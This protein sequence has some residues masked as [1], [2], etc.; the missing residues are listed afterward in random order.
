MERRS[1]MSVCHPSRYDPDGGRN[2]HRRTPSSWVWVVVRA[3]GT[4]NQPAAAPSTFFCA[5]S[6]VVRAAARRPRRAHN[7]LSYH[8]HRHVQEIAARFRCCRRRRRRHRH[9]KRCLCPV[10]CGCFRLLD[11]QAGSDHQWRAWAR[12]DYN[13]HEAV[14]GPREAGPEEAR[15]DRGAQDRVGPPGA[16][17]A[18]GTSSANRQHLAQRS[19]VS[20][21][22]GRVVSS[23]FPLVLLYASA[24]LLPV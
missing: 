2:V 9:K 13:A 22:R 1:I 21:G 5:A 24:S 6:S 19:H 4:T 14:H 8:H 15:Q 17:P 3:A 18:R 23:P 7:S 12:W 11:Q 20:F 10:G 16:P